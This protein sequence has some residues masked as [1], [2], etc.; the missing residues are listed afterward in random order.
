MYSCTIGNRFLSATEVRRWPSDTEGAVEPP[1][2]STLPA[3]VA[4][5][6]SHSYVAT[7]FKRCNELLISAIVYFFLSSFIF[8]F[9]AVLHIALCDRLSLLSPTLPYRPN[10]GV[11]L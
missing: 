9:S 1:I 7:L 8:D 4:F 5:Q 10:C 2:K 3:A 11:F 6:Q